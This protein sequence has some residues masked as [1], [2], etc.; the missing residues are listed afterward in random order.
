MTDDDLP[1]V[2]E[3]YASTR[4][5]ELAVTGWPREVQEAFLFEQHEKQHSHYRLHFPH[6]EWLIIERGGEA[7]GRLYLREDQDA[8]H[9][10]DISLLPGHRRQ[11]VGEAI[12]RDVQSQARQ[13]GRAVTIHVEKNNPARSLYF[14][15]GFEVSADR[16]VY[17]LMRAG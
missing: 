6:A 1:F 14:R 15:L 2:A 13:Q 4:R 3:L 8:L 9:I 17:D 11:G 12:L 10:L 7:V 5:E 16:G